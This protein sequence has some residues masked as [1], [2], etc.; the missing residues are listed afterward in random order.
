MEADDSTIATAVLDQ[1][2]GAGGQ[3]S[4][5]RSDDTSN[6]DDPP[7]LAAGVLRANEIANMGPPSENGEGDW[8]DDESAYGS[9]P[10][11]PPSP[12]SET[13]SH[14]TLG[15][16][17]DLV[18][19]DEQSDHTFTG[20]VEETQGGN[21]N[22][23]IPLTEIQFEQAL[24]EPNIDFNDAISSEED[25]EI[26]LSEMIFPFQISDEVQVAPNPYIDR[27]E[28]TSGLHIRHRGRVIEAVTKENASSPELGLFKLFFPQKLL[29]SLAAWTSKRLEK[30][31][32]PKVSE[33]EFNAYM[34]LEIAMSF[35]G[36]SR[37]SD[38]WSKSSYN[39]IEK[40]GQTMAR[41]RFSFIRGAVVLHDPDLFDIETAHKDPLWHCRDFLDKMAE[42]CANLAVPVGVCSLD[43]CGYRSKARSKCICFIPSKPDKYAVRFYAVV[44]WK[45]LYIHTFEHNGTGVS[46]E[47]KAVD[48]YLKRFPKL[49]TPYRN[50]F[51]PNGIAKRYGI[52]KLSSTAL[53]TLML[54]MQEHLRRANGE[55][56]RVI[57]CDNY[58]TRHSFASALKIIS[59]G[60]IRMIGTV[61]GN[62][63]GKDNSQNV[64]RAVE[65]LSNAARGSWELVRAYDPPLTPNGT[66]TVA[67]CAGF[68]VFKDS[69]VVVFYSNDLASTPSQD[70]LTSDDQEAIDCCHGLACCQRWLGCELT[71]RSQL[72][73]PAPIV[74]YN[75]YMNAVDRMDQ[76]RSTNPTQRKEMRISMTLFTAM[77]DVAINNA[78]AIYNV[79]GKS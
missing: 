5:E 1:V 29:K 34:G 60:K 12:E 20:S 8:L 4:G 19:D 36:A 13:N 46:L 43:E 33:T 28:A 24:Q 77:I 15:R 53:W 47:M 65:R 22:P 62:F 72:M 25:A 51:G 31:L 70:F 75:K 49:R 40:F 32:Q 18:D 61:R 66:K 73:V 2:I 45:Y 14:F 79:M 30:K 52:D 74:A 21:A 27:L 11:C 23:L 58:Y 17:E 44:D 42:R 56:K 67:D 76:K 39:Y 78:H 50:V 59:D 64:K 57:F 35:S 68:I 41:E 38:C 48:R 63:I 37:M 54:A 10:D 3:A 69:K 7:L 16:D 71:H 55:H 26:G 9:L 6:N